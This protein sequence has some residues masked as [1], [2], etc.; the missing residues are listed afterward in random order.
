MSGVVVIGGGFSGA[1]A[2][3]RLSGEGR[4]P[5]LLERA[6]RLGGRA[7]SFQL[8]DAGETVDY[9]HHVLMQCCTA[10]TG[11]LLRIGMP[12]TVQFQSRLAIPIASPDATAVLRSSLLPGILH[13]APALLRYRVLSFPDRLRTIQAGL[14]LS[15][16]GGEK[17]PPFGNWLAN[18]GQTEATIRCLWDPISIATLNAPT[19]AVGL[20]AARKVFRD[21]FFHADGANMG[22]FTV[23][24]SQIFEAARDYIEQRGGAIRLSAPVRQ[25]IVEDGCIRGVQLVTG[26]TIECTAAVCAVPPA[27]FARLV[28]EKEDAALDRLIARAAQIRWA[29][30]VNLH[31]WFDRPVLDHAF[32]VAVNSPVQA[33]FDV[34]QLHREPLRDGVTHLVFSQSAADE[35]LEHPNAVI[36]Q[37][38]LAELSKLLPSAREAGLK[39]TLV[40]RHPQA[41]FIPQPEADQLRPPSKTPI[42]GLYLAGDWTATGWPSTIEGAVRSGIAAAAHA[43]QC[44]TESANGAPHG[45]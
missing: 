27:E 37:L 1:A 17:D 34:T 16:H 14:T 4:R 24:L 20:H 10:A 35:W 41:T 5:L 30:I 23:A 32:V 11:F 44:L 36:V 38:L 21:A 25:L 26:E 19:S 12:D 13:L 6:P 7:A 2:A 29:P 33:L 22:F 43:E 45:S 3:C 40:V 28:R 39:R 8:A 31:V 9:G 18:H 42:R 15:L